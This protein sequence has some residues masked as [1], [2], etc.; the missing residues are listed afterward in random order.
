M[1][2]CHATSTG[3]SKNCD[4]IIPL[5]YISSVHCKVYKGIEQDDGTHQVLIED[6]SRV[7]IS[8]ERDGKVSHCLNKVLHRREHQP[9]LLPLSTAD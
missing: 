3:R 8:I 5:P 2:L 9:L 1:F 6:K 4:I 7:G